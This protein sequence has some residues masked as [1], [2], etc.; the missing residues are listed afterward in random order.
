MRFILRLITH[1]IA[2]AIGFA[3]GIYAL[4]ILIA[5]PSVDRAMLET[6]A[7]EA[8]YQT[9]FVRDLEGSDFLHWGEGDVS[10]SAEKIVHQGTMA[11]GPDYKVYLTTEFVDTKAGFEKIKA[12]SLQVGEVKTFDGF[13]TNLPT[14]VDI[15]NYNTV[16]IWCETFGAFITAAKYK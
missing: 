14:G 12:S 7:K 15:E 3:G 10:I 11:P 2:L 8:T 13:I 6:S 16:V 9:S 1:V 5:P 4:P